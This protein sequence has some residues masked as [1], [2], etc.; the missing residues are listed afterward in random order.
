MAVCLLIV[1]L[2]VCFPQAVLTCGVLQNLS[3]HSLSADSISAI[4]QAV[5]RVIAEGKAPGAVVLVGHQGEVVFE[6][7]YGNRSLEPRVEP[8][9]LDTVFDLASLTKVIVTAPSIMLLAQQ[10]RLRLDDPAAKYIP[11]FAKRG[12]G[13][14]TI[15][16]LLTHYSGLPADLRLSKKRKSLAG[17]IL[18][19]IYQ[20]KLLAP[21]G[22]RFIY[23]DLGFI[24]LGKVVEKVSGKSLDAF[25]NENFLTVLNMSS[26]RF[27]PL[28]LDRERIAPTERNKDGSVMRGEVH[29]P[30][31]ALLGGVAGDAGLF[32]TARDL[33]RFCQ[34]FLNE[35]SLDGVSVLE[36]ETVRLMV[37][38]QSPADKEN[39]RGF[40]WDINSAYSSVK[41]SHFS[42]K[43]YGHTGY[44][45]TSLWIDPAIDSYLIILTNRV[46]PD[47]KGNVKELRTQIAD[48]VGSALLESNTPNSSDELRQE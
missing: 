18:T 36:P 1:F 28:R 41:G 39:V 11:S 7:A 21:P 48:I 9:T 44:T 8:M 4:D 24:V 19:R 17:S 14:I 15:R 46:H 20:V 25:A 6:K 31:A 29:D 26:S 37:S 45:G 5:E 2:L 16:H 32:S 38:P 47:G 33:S 3:Q 22:S 12:K 34:M 10:G 23:S 30:L 27:R 40:G 42:S 35:G 13:K 43:S